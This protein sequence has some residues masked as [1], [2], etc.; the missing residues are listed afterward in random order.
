MQISFTFGHIF[1]I[2]QSLLFLIMHSYRVEEP[3][4]D[5]GFYTFKKKNLLLN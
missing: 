5:I 2:K 1:F 4:L 3:P